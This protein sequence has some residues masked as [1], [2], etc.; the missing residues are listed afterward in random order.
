MKVGTDGVL[1]GAWTPLSPFTFHLSTILDIGTG[2]GLIALMLA[3]R[4][5]GAHID[6]IDIDPEAV[7]QAADNFAASPWS[8][9]LHAQCAALQKYQMSNI[10]YQ[11]FN[12]YWRITSPIDH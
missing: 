7:S 3:Q 11:M 6:A 4:C 5:P 12:G 9:R 2:S 10:K 8:D 1:L